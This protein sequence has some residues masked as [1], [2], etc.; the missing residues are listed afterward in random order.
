MKGRA[1]QPVL[2]DP[3]GSLD[4]NVFPV[5]IESRHERSVY[6]DSVLVKYPD[7]AREVGGSS[8]SFF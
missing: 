3:G 2:L 1:F 5:L 6:L 8:E 7:A 4:E